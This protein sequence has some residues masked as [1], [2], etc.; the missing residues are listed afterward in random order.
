MNQGNS[1]SDM[2]GETLETLTLKNISYNQN[3]NYFR[4][5]ASNLC[6]TD[7]FT[8][9]VRLLV[10]EQ[11][12]VEIVTKNDSVCVGQPFMLQA[13]AD[14][15][16]S[17]NYHFLWNYNL[18][19]Q[20]IVFDS[21]YSDKTYVVQLFDNCSLNPV[22]DTF[23]VYV[24]PSLQLNIVSS[25]DT[26]CFGN[27]A[28]LKA[29]PFGGD[30]L[31][32]QYLWF[33][34]S[35]TNRTVVVD[36]L[37]NSDYLLKLEDGCSK[38]SIIDT[39]R[40]FVRDDLNLKLITTEDSIC[41]GKDVTVSA[42]VS[43]G[44]PQTYQYIWN[45]SPNN[46]SFITKTALTKS[47]FFKI[48]FTDQCSPKILSDSILIYVRDSLDVELTAFPD[49]SVCVGKEVILKAIAKGGKSDS[50]LF[51]WSDSTFHQDSLINFFP[52]QTAVY[53]VLLTD[54]CSAKGDSASLIV[55]VLPPLSVGLV[56]DKDSVCSGEFVSLRAFANGGNPDTYNF[57]WELFSTKSDSIADSPQV[58][59]WY[60]V[61]LSDH[62]TVEPATDSMQIFVREVNAD[63]NYQ[64]NYLVADFEAFEKNAASYVWDFGDSS[65]SNLSHVQHSYLKEG[66]YLVCLTI[67][68][69]SN[70]SSIKCDQITVIENS[71]VENSVD[72]EIELFPNPAAEQIFLKI[73]NID[74]IEIR[75]RILTM[76]GKELISSTFLTS[77][78][79]ML[80]IK[81]LKKGIYLTEIVVGDRM[82]L[83]KL[84]VLD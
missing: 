17:L 57:D 24:R 74:H 12:I 20:A 51:H 10:R 75:F 8:E 52:S 25:E 46:A 6:T 18:G 54:N 81:S 3:N 19:E 41:F 69:W 39:F 37:V 9:E 23:S 14:G 76:E 31:N 78:P 32:Y 44:N 28:T 16:D 84:I 80:D 64:L 38:Q 70:C 83:K 49:T 43:G 7:S 58:N 65:Y 71:M 53:S 35:D 63:W 15:G 77:K 30:Y 42:S 21:L 73:K 40:L 55:S 50:Y 33:H 11:I 29:Q 34:N 62:C 45:N 13:M 67:T 56:S 72:E 60:K 61:V 47:A 1:W 66:N 79:I 5:K 82:Y 68:D 36:P 4:I 22:Y 2:S 26:I 48:D 59:T 27:S